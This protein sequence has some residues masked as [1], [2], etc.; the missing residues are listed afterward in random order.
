MRILVPTG[1]PT[2]ERGRVPALPQPEG[3]LSQGGP[4]H[5]AQR[6]R[7]QRGGVG[8]WR[9]GWFPTLRSP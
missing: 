1:G 2:G 9:V 8:G 3:A 5:P 6:H 4:V 7:G